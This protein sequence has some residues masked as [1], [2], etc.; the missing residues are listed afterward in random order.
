[1]VALLNPQ[2]CINKENGSPKCKA[3]YESLGDNGVKIFKDIFRNNNK[4]LVD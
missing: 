1:M 3:L 4:K 2:K